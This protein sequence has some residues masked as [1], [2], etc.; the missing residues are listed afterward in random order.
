MP[1]ERPR[2][3]HCLSAAAYS[4]GLSLPHSHGWSFLYQ[5]FGDATRSRGLCEKSEIRLQ[6]VELLRQVLKN[7]NQRSNGRKGIAKQLPD[8]GLVTAKEILME[9]P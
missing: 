7:K 5:Q 9:D 3:F 6:A 2:Q 8:D 1:V 4:V